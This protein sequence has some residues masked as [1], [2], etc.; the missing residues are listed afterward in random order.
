MVND[1]G[2]VVAPGRLGVAF[3]DERLVADAGIVLP[4]TLAARLG[5]EALVDE[6]V[7]LGD[8]AGAANAGAKVMTLVAAMALGADSIDDCDILRAGRTAALLGHRA[9]APSTLG[10]FL[11]SFTFGHV[12]QLDRVLG[13]SLERA[14]RAGAGPGE[15]RLV[16]DV[17]SF[18][19]EVH[20]YQKQAPA[21]ATQAS[22]ATTRCS[23]RAL[24]PA[25]CCTSACARARPTARAARCASSRS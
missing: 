15:G 8:R 1:G 21:S 10:R 25:R 3:D 6:A 9:A 23:P 5:I 17:D 20:G 18:V 11:R 13:E 16:V 24:I 22:A 7:D 14:W 4:A 12:R 2:L 19:G